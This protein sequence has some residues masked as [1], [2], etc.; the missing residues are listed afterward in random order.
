MILYLYTYKL[1]I[2][3]KLIGYFKSYMDDHKLVKKV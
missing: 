2:T 1:V 3:V